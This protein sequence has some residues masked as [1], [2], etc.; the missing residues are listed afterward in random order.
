M[1][2]KGGAKGGVK[3]VKKVLKSSNNNAEVATNGG[4]GKGK[5]KGKG[6]SSAAAA[7]QQSA[8][9]KQ[10][11]VKATTQAWTKQPAKA[12]DKGKGK[13][14]GKGKSDNNGAS[15]GGKKGKGKGKDQVK[16]KGKDQVKGKGK[17]KGKGKG[18]G[19]GKRTCAPVD[20]EFWSKKLEEENRIVL[21]SE[22]LT[23]ICTL[24]KESQGWGWVVPD[25]IEA[26]PQEARDKMAEELE[27][28]K[29]SG[30]EVKE[31]NRI[32]FRKPDVEADFKIKK[33]SWVTFQVYID[34][35]GVGACEVS[36][37]GGDDGI[38]EEAEA[39]AA[40]EA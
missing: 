8:W 30:K 23:G 28:L 14:K 1:G 13:G 20:S 34:D 26:V 10:A 9:V 3:G 32:Y 17:R 7:P 4:A 31:E 21:D 11:A 27:T 15:A 33:D 16:G 19:K 25:D 2:G 29:A 38:A 18:K 6:K 24:Y 35:K 5:G 22:P 36:N 40:P 37:A 12:A 39:E